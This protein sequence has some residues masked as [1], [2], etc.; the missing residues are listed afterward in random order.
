METTTQR[1]PVA[2]TDAE[3]QAELSGMKRLATGL[4]ILV[5]LIFF[6]ATPFTERHW[7]VGFVAAFAEAAMVGALADWFAVTALFR[8]PLGIPIPHTAIIPRRKDRIGQILGRFVQHNFLNEEVIAQR[9]QS[10]DVAQRVGQWLC[11][12][13]Q[14]GRVADTA[15][16]VLGGMGQVVRDDDIQH[17]IERGIVDRVERVPVTPL[18]GR[19][20]A[21]VASGE[22]RQ[23][24]L[25]ALV[26]MAGQLLEENKGAIREAVSR[27]MPRLTFGLLDDAVYRKLVSPLESTLEQV[28]NDPEHALRGEFNTR[29]AQFIEGLQH[30]EAVIARGEELKREVLR[31]PVVRELASSIWA[32]VKAALLAPRSAENTDDTPIQRALFGAGQALL[33]D[34][35]LRA[36]INQ[37]AEQAARYMAREYGNEVF[38]L[39]THTVERWD[40]EATASKLELQVGRDLQFIRINGTLV[41]GLVGLLIHAFTLLLGRV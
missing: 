35:A 32:D 36:K 2:T 33:N 39:I 10:L 11:D 7:L 16:D 37:W 20:L 31:Q 40:A 12:P 34:A 5:T 13:K 21:T 8:H 24:L 30:D 9:V 14:S 4:L 26:Q 15:A 23:E 3:R 19:L 41:G 1:P 29:L 28:R 18:F 22:R 38:T 27:E 6:V 17:L 25:Y